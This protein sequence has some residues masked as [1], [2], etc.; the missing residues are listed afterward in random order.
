MLENTASNEDE[1]QSTPLI[2][3][4]S[5]DLEVGA[6]NTRSNSGNG[7]WNKILDLKEA[8]TQLVFSLPMIFIGV[9]YYLVAL[10]S[11]M[12][13]GHLGTLQLA[14]ATLANSWFIVTGASIMVTIFALFYAY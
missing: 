4:A 13:A 2:S 12:F 10:V 9:S 6:E 7:W 8:K 5:H 3:L 11:V 14:G 1:T